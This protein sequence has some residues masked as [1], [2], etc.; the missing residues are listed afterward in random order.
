MY[1][2]ATEYVKQH[3]IFYL[4]SNKK[5]NFDDILKY[6]KSLNN[7]KTIYLRTGHVLNLLE[8]DGI[9]VSSLVEDFSDDEDDLALWY[10]MI[11]IV[12]GINDGT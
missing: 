5:A 8:D 4:L 7:D 2:E 10:E 3:I 1:N 6:M 12:E 11:E 9:V